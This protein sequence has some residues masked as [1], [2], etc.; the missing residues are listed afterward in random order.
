MLSWSNSHEDSCCKSETDSFSVVFACKDLLYRSLHVE[1]TS[2][3]EL[4]YDRTESKI[5]LQWLKWGLLI[6]E[7]GSI[8][9]GRTFGKPP[10]FVPSKTQTA[11]V[12]S[13]NRHHPSGR[14][15]I[16]IS[17]LLTARSKFF[18]ICYLDNRISPHKDHKML[19]TEQIVSIIPFSNQRTKRFWHLM[20]SSQTQRLL[21][22]LLITNCKKVIL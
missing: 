2:R 21:E 3:W 6:Q 19:R 9:G 1:E 13:K 11:F 22:V 18:A 12:S 4:C 8:I 15:I 17:D 10:Y 7:G 14:K 5:D 16:L 20:G